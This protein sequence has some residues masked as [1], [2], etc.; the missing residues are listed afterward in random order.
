M[1]NWFILAVITAI[2]IFNSCTTNSYSV[3]LLTD[4]KIVLADTYTKQ[5]VNEDGKITKK[6]V[7]AIFI[8]YSLDKVLT[9][10]YNAG[11]TKILSIETWC[12]NF[13]G[14]IPIRNVLIRCSKG[15]D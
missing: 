5:S 8:G 7:P 3:Q 10:A 1:K 4:N 12:S 2:V 11:Y 6:E 13:L 15:D 14:I 9:E